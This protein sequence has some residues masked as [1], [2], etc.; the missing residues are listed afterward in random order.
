MKRAER[1][2]LLPGPR[3][4]KGVTAKTY[5]GETLMDTDQD[6]EDDMEFPPGLFTGGTGKSLDW[7]RENCQCYPGYRRTEKLKLVHLSTHPQVTRV[8]DPERV[9]GRM[10]LQKIYLNFTI[11][12]IHQR[13]CQSANIKESIYCGQVKACMIR[14]EEQPFLWCV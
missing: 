3:Q 11:P 4:E 12:S 13:L 10:L 2:L 9:L 7:F 14:K 6:I 1:P 8:V 5:G